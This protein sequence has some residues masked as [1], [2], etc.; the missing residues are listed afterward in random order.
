MSNV[1][2]VVSRV[3]PRRLSISFAFIYSGSCVS[4]AWQRPS[5]VG[6]WEYKQIRT[7]RC[8]LIYAF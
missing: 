3:T 4:V 5:E 6:P 7:L 1:S 8:K 2:S